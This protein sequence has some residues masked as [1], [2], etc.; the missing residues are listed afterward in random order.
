[1]AGL[2]HR[3][4]GSLPLGIKSISKTQNV[5]SREGNAY[6]ILVG[7]QKDRHLL[8]DLRVR[9]RTILKWIFKK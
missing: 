3:V 5:E 9:R 6:R 8:E 2:K 1:V 7:N 4:L